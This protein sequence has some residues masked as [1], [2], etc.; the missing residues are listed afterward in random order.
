LVGGA[1]VSG[2]VTFFVVNQTYSVSFAETGLPP[3]TGWWVNVSGGGSAVATDSS[4]SV[5]EPNGTYEYSVSSANANY[6]S[7]RGSLVVHGAGVSKTVVFY[8][9]A[10]SVT[11]EESGLPTGTSWWVDF[12]GTR[13]TKTGNLEFTTIPNGTYSFTLGAAAAYTA[14]RTSGSVGVHG[15]AVLVPVSFAP[16]VTSSGNGTAPS[17]FLGLPAEEGYG[18]VGG[19]ILAILVVAAAVV[20]LRRRGR[21]RPAEPPKSDASDSPA[22]P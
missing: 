7:P 3:S 15:S 5:E 2:G 17:T 13:Q 9:S 12:Y 8:Q 16:T 19:I 14:N 11:F 10:Y 4:L 6:S 22:S 18:A 1:S 21:G 20:L